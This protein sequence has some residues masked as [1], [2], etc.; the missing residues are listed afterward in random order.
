MPRRS[1]R[2]H[3]TVDQPNPGLD[4]IEAETGPHQVEERNGRQQLDLDPVDLPKQGDA[5]LKYQRRARDRVDDM[6]MRLDIGLETVADLDIDAGES[7]GRLVDLIE[8]RS[9][10]DLRCR[11][12]GSAKP[13]FSTTLEG[14]S[15]LR[16]DEFRT[17]G[18]KSDDRQPAHDRDQPR[19]PDG[20]SRRPVTGSQEP[21]RAST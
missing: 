8:G 21:K 13:H 9:V 3:M 10:H 19:T 2:E 6:A 15:G 14:G 7:I 17:G 11:M 12:P 20:V 16:G 18:T 1:G 4:R 5:V